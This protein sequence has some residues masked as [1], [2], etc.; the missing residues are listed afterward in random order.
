MKTESLTLRRLKCQKHKDRDL[1]TAIPS[2]Q[3][4]RFNS[5]QTESLTTGNLQCQQHVDRVGWSGGTMMLRKLSV[6]GRFT[7]SV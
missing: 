5:A 3:R 4:Q 2:T 6:P 7:D 1:K